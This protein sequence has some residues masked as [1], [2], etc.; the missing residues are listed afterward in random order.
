MPASQRYIL[1]GVTTV[2][3]SN[4]WPGEAIAELREES[5]TDLTLVEGKQFM[6]VHVDRKKRRN[7]NGFEAKFLR[8]V[9]AKGYILN[10]NPLTGAPAVRRH[11]GDVNGPPT[12]S[13]P[14]K[15]SATAASPLPVPEQP[16]RRR[17][18]KPKESGP[19]PQQQRKRKQQTSKEHAKLDKVAHKRAQ[20]YIYKLKR[21]Q[22]FSLP[23][24]RSPLRPAQYLTKAEGKPYLRVQVTMR[25][26]AKV[27]IKKSGETMRVVFLK[28]HRKTKGGV[29]GKW[30]ADHNLATGRKVC[31]LVK[32]GALHSASHVS[33]PAPEQHSAAPAPK[34]AGPDLEVAVANAMRDRG[35]T[36]AE[37]A[38]SIAKLTQQAQGWA[39]ASAALIRGSTRS[40]ILRQQKRVLNDAMREMDAE[41]RATLDAALHV[42]GMKFERSHGADLAEALGTAAG[43]NDREIARL[44]V[45][46]MHLVEDA[47]RLDE[48]EALHADRAVAQAELEAEYAMLFAHEARRVELREAKARRKAQAAMRS[49]RNRILQLY[50]DVYDIDDEEKMWRKEEEA[51]AKAV[52]AHVHNVGGGGGGGIY[53]AGAER[54]KAHNVAARN[55]AVQRGI[56]KGKLKGKKGGGAGGAPPVDPRVVAEL[57]EEGDVF[58]ALRILEAATGGAAGSWDSVYDYDEVGEEKIAG[59]G[60]GNHIERF[61]GGGGRG[62]V[63][64]MPSMRSDFTF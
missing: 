59:H 53:N 52:A 26:P 50:P 14:A 17:T 34:D 10:I 48:L 22:V 43:R 61:G 1:H 55:V 2:Y 32:E 24:A 47:A 41:S 7:V 12:P 25:Q 28:L 62:A 13:S 54:Q 31:A 64:A 63:E 19:P 9:E 39:T 37:H 35:L 57:E 8:L 33:L 21:A 45:Q 56:A 11:P 3:K 4:A 60:F 6:V 42:A 18:P 38:R 29:G 51:K 30:I 58:A 15:H 20:R 23:D 44:A 40:T 27:R 16:K 49:R 46:R 36:N 5:G